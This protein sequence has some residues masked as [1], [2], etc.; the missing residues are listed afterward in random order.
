MTDQPRIRS[1]PLPAIAQS[2][3]QRFHQIAVFGPSDAVLSRSVLRGLAM[4]IKASSDQ[5]LL[6]FRT[7]GLIL[8][9]DRAFR[10]LHH[11]ER[12]RALGAAPCRDTTGLSRIALDLN[13]LFVLP[14]RQHRVFAV[15][16][17]AAPDR[18]VRTHAPCPLVLAVYIFVLLPALLCRGEAHR[19]V[20]LYVTL[21]RPAAPD[22]LE[23]LSSGNGWLVDLAPLG[24]LWTDLYRS[25]SMHRFCCWTV[26][27]KSIPSPAVEDNWNIPYLGFTPA[28]YERLRL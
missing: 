3:F 19:M 9:A 18:S 25:C 7:R 4:R 27:T 24:M 13:D 22:L 26:S 28:K 12:G 5:A 11:T 15:D 16:D 2:S 10:A 20:K 17:Q 23:K 14:C 8:S 21:L 6:S 1:P